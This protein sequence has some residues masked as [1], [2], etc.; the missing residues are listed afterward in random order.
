MP[1]ETKPRVKIL[2]PDHEERISANDMHITA[3]KNEDDKYLAVIMKG[4]EQDGQ[5]K[6]KPY[7]K[8][9]MTWHTYEQA[10]MEGAKQYPYIPMVSEDG[11]SISYPF[12][13]EP[14]ER[15]K[16]K[17]ITDAQERRAR[18]AQRLQEQ[19]NKTRAGNLKSNQFICQECNGIFDK[20]WTDEEAQAE[21]KELFPRFST[22]IMAL[23]CDDCF[24]T[25]R[26]REKF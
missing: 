17:H 24:K 20:G 22:A 25:I 4:T 21:A 5:R 7:A 13:V 10:V 14:E 26:A 12:F 16:P 18:K 8:S 3:I 2:R 11:Q 19:Y 1:A 23:V 6:F 15:P 9:K